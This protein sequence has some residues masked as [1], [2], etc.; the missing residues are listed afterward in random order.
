MG[1][2]PDTGSSLQT[3]GCP[4]P[5]LFCAHDPIATLTVVPIAEADVPPQ[6]CSGVAI[7]PRSRTCPC[8]FPEL[9]MLE[10]IAPSL[11]APNVHSP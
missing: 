5:S 7:A 3:S 6:A 9:L 4:L 8:T 2:E 10:A 1:P 11:P